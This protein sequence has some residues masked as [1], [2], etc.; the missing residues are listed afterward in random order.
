[1]RK[2]RAE[3]IKK[4]QKVILLLKENKVNIDYIWPWLKY[5][6]LNMYAQNKI[7]RKTQIKHVPSS[8]F[9]VSH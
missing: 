8:F 3:G 9:P 5:I 6:H 2:S 7:C 1:M 4:S